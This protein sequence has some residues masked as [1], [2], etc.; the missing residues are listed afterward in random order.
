MHPHPSLQSN[1]NNVLMYMYY[2]TLGC[3]DVKTRRQTHRVTQIV[4]IKGIK[5]LKQVK[6]RTETHTDK[7]IKKRTQ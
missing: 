6:S 7:K 5:A 1:G 2:H 3:P 4:I